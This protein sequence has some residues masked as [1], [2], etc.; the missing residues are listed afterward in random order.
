VLEQPLAPEV[1]H[2]REAAEAITVR[3]D[4]LQSRFAEQAVDASWAS[5]ATQALSDDLAKHLTAEVR[6]AGVECRTTICRAEIAPATPEAG[7]Q[8]VETWIRNRTWTGRGFA[9]GDGGDRVVLYL[10]RPDR[11]DDA[12]AN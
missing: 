3:R 9:A 1:A 7:Q 5:S 10:A 6:V 11:E 2:E 4:R 8:F 12:F